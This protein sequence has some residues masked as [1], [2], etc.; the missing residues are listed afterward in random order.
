MTNT[1]QNLG[2]GMRGLFEGWHVLVLLILTGV[3]AVP[4]LLVVFLVV[5][6]ASTGARQPIAAPAGWYPD[7]NGVRRWWDGTT[8]TEHT[9]P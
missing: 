1:E 4:I 3:L 6:G 9:Q 8:W 7:Q 5:R 2:V